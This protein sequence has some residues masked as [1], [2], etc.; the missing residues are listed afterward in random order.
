MPQS[1][2]HDTDSCYVQLGVEPGAA[3]R[4]IEAAYWRSARELRG[5]PALAPYTAAY[6]ALVSRVAP[7]RG[8]VPPALSVAEATAAPPTKA[9]TAV[10][11]FGWP[12]N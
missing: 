10:S 8:V 12:A 3:M 4:D 2:S 6:E 5:Q 11:K 1:N 7:R 9:S